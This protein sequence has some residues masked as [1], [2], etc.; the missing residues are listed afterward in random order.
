MILSNGTIHFSVADQRQALFD[1][2]LRVYPNGS[3][4]NVLLALEKVDENSI[5]QKI[6]S[7]LSEEVLFS[8]KQRVPQTHQGKG[9][10]NTQELA[11]D[12]APIV[13]EQPIEEDTVQQLSELHKSFVALL[14]EC[15]QKIKE[16][17]ES[18]EVK[19]ADIGDGNKI[20]RGLQ[21]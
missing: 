17:T 18:G 20:G 19:L 5:I 21:Y 15:I 6:S 13:T 14:F 4:E 8:K 9:D 3:W 7:T 2:W 11:L 12:F 1:K 10:S 16:K